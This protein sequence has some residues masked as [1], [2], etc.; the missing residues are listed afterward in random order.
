MDVWIAAFPNLIQV[1]DPSLRPVASVPL[2]ATETFACL[3]VATH[4]ESSDIQSEEAWKAGT[5]SSLNIQKD[6]CYVICRAVG[7]LENPQT[8]LMIQEWYFATVRLIK[9]VFRI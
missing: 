3:L 5:S 4:P 6:T 2:I 8:T 1:P 9:V 7:G